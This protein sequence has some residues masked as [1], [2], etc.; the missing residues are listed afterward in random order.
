MVYSMS[1]DF[2]VFIPPEGKPYSQLRKMAERTEKLGY[3]SI[4]ISDH[5]HGMYGSQAGS[6]MECWTLGTALSAHTSRVRFGQLTMA[7][8]FRNPALTAKMAATLDNITGGRVILSIG[9]GWH[10][11][12]FRGYGY[13]FG[14]LGSRSRR[15]EEAARIIK[16]L[17]SEE[18]PSFD[19]KYYSIDGA[20]CN[21]KPIQ[22]PL[23]LMIAGGGEKRTLRTAALY[24]DM[25]NYSAWIGSP[26]AF[27][28]KTDVLYKH[29]DRLGRDPD[30]ITKTWA[31]FVYI[32][33]DDDSAWEVAYKNHP[34][35]RW[36]NNGG[37]LVG[38][39]ETIKGRIEEYRE[40][41]VDY[42][43]L[44]FLGGEWKKEV[45]MFKE[46]VIR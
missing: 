44:S 36:E 46:Q 45:N 21:P 6:R 28:E 15:L 29:C 41:G 33:E 23:P 22:D 26:E 30:E 1:D 20:F 43:I 12:E 5:V 38:S 2:G 34:K 27:A 8:P 18:K 9:A 14:S 25:T 16:L 10:A 42:F 39:P 40:V 31:A 24:G 17:W 3:D 32:N 19:G 37:G 4:W 35:E 7:V 13:D 11:D